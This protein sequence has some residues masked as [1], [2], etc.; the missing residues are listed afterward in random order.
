[1]MKK[2]LGSV[3]VLIGLVLLGSVTAAII[4]Q[5]IC[6]IPG[7]VALSAAGLAGVVLGGKMILRK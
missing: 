4:R 6:S 2:A 5:G 7:T 1:M 3:L